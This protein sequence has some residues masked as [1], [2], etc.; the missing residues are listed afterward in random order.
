MQHGPDVEEQTAPVL[1]LTPRCLRALLAPEQGSAERLEALTTRH[2]E[3]IV[4]AF[5]PPDRAPRLLSMDRLNGIT[6]S[7]LRKMHLA[8]EVD[9]G[10]QSDDPGPGFPAPV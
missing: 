4:A 3:I 7:R 8:S 2:P 10:S 1:I 6:R 9:S 5:L